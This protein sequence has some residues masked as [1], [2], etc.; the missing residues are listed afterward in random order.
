MRPVYA[1]QFEVDAHQDLPANHHTTLAIQK[2]GA[3][4]TEWY[5]RQGIDLEFPIDGGEV[6][7]GNGHIIDVTVT[8]VEE[9]TSIWELSWTYPS[10]NDE[11]V[12][13]TSHCV[14]AR[15]GKRTEV[16]ISIRI[17]SVAFRMTPVDFD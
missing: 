9:E 4:L 14:V 7:P 5:G 16:S 6:R 8:A 10:V 11:S 2:V 3:W 1:V 15:D 17:A 13:W 12:R